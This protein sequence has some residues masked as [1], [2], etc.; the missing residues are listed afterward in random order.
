MYT[1]YLIF[2]P[3]IQIWVNLEG[4]AME[5]VGIFNGH[6]V[7]LRPFGVFYGNLLYFIVI[8]YI[9]S[10]FWYVVQRKICH[11]LVQLN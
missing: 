7:Y 11:P 6:L 10:R 4:L 2:K 8:W 5:D 1:T 9:F 3:K